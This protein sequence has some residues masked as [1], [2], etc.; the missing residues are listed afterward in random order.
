MAIPV[1]CKADICP[2]REKCPLQSAL[3]RIGGKWKLSI[4]CS[5]M[6]DGTTRYGE[7]RRK[8]KG[9]TNTMLA[10]SLRELEADGLVRRVQYS[11][12]PVRVE[13]TAT[14]VCRRLMPILEQLT[15]WETS[16]ITL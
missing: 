6:N 13:Y 8:I 11:E 4:I 2:C 10:N 16:L 7:L 14:E 1:N 3:S 15:A 5:L 9:I 12:V